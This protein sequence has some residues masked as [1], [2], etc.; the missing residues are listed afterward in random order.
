MKNVNVWEFDF[1]S[2]TE[3]ENISVQY[4]TYG[5][6]RSFVINQFQLDEG[7][8][9][10]SLTLDDTITEETMVNDWFLPLEFI[11]DRGL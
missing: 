4:Y 6:D 7:G 5:D 10:F 11:L 1:Y 8:V 3:G 2:E 9:D